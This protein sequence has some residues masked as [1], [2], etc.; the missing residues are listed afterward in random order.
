MLLL[1]NVTLVL[2]QKGCNKIL[3]CEMCGYAAIQKNN[4]DTLILYDAYRDDFGGV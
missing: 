4:F 1:L 3:E 2:Y